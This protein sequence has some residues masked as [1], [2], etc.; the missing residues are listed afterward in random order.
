MLADFGNRRRQLRH[1][2][3]NF[4]KGLQPTGRA[5]ALAKFAKFSVPSLPPKP[6]ANGMRHGASETLATA[7]PAELAV[8][9]TGHDL[10]G[11]SVPWEYLDTHIALTI[12]G[13]VALAEWP[14]F[15]YGQM[16]KGPTHPSLQPLIEVKKVTLD[17]VEAFIDQLFSF[18]DASPPMLLVDGP[19]RPMMHA[20][21]ATL[22]MYYE[23]RF[24]A[25]EMTIVLQNMR[26]AYMEI[27]TAS[28]DVHGIFV[29]WAGC[30]GGRF[31][32][33]QRGAGGS[34]A[35]R[36]RTGD[37]DTRHLPQ[38]VLRPWSLV[39]ESWDAGRH[40]PLQAQPVR[41]TREHFVAERRENILEYCSVGAN[42]FPAE[43]I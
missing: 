6:S 26:D 43:R 3:T 2:V 27:A 24:K 19:C 38:R 32:C 16:G 21:L 7:V 17:F 35:R 4:I 14:P 31:T 5:G 29:D 10:T 22:I 18:H 11:L 23:E 41:M 34:D 20:T 30:G 12:P 40:G 15:P 13:A 37:A 9:T 28:D 42:C 25:N 36:R 8:H 1:K 39:D 33:P